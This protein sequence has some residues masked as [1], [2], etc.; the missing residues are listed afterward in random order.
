MRD[1]TLAYPGWE[2]RKINA[3]GKQRRSGLAV[4]RSKLP[5]DIGELHLRPRNLQSNKP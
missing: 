3:S 1:Q 4:Q 2:M 5:P